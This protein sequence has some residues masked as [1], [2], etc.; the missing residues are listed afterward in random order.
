[1]NIKP[2]WEWGLGR[3]QEKEHPPSVKLKTKTEKKQLGYKWSQVFPGQQ[4][5]FFSGEAGKARVV[6]KERN[7]VTTMWEIQRQGKNHQ[8]A[9][10][11]HCSHRQPHKY[12]KGHHSLP[13]VIGIPPESLSRTG[14]WWGLSYVILSGES[15]E[16][17]GGVCVEEC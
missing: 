13:T 16:G 9:S 8:G 4:A 17:T 10:V 1:M 12:C 15:R 3:V 5:M 11:C 7:K 2:R 6:Y 14:R